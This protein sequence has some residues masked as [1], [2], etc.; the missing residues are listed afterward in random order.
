[1]NIQ[2]TA[3]VLA[4]IKLI[5]NREITELV[6]REWHDIIGHIEYADA[7]VAVREHRKTSTDYLLPG[8][9]VQGARRARDARERDARKHRALPA[10]NVITMPPDFHEMTQ[11]AIE[12]HRAQRAAES[13]P[14]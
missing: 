1:V 6:I 4:K 5:D 9:V 13:R 3:A 12:Q 10:G 11:R 7:I 8:H 2:E 14:A